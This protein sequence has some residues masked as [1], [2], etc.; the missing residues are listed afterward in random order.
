MGNTLERIQHN[1]EN[2]MP[3]V[4]YQGILCKLDDIRWDYTGNRRCSEPR[5]DTHMNHL[6][7]RNGFGEN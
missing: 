6:L 3:F 5:D 4:Y 2:K 1:K 7:D